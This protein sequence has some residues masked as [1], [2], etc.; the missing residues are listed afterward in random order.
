M[1]ADEP[2]PPAPAVTAAP[3][4]RAALVRLGRAHR[5]AAALGTALVI[6]VLLGIASRPAAPA[7][8]RVV[9]ASVPAVAAPDAQTSPAPSGD[10]A[11]LQ[12]PEPEAAPAPVPVRPVS[13]DTAAAP[14][15][16]D[17]EI[18]EPKEPASATAPDPTGTATE[19]PAPAPAPVKHVTVVALA[20]AQ[21]LDV[22]GP[23]TRAPYLA[24]ELR[25]RGLLLHRYFETAH[26]NLP[27][28]VAL[29][30]GQTTDAAARSLP[31]QLERAGLRWRA[32]VEGADA[33]A[34]APPAPCPPP[35]PAPDGSATPIDRNPFQFLA[36]IAAS[37]DCTAKVTGLAPLAA[38]LAAP[39]ADAPAFTL[40]VPGACDAG[41][42][43]ACPAGEPDGIARADAW[44]RE[45]IPPLL[46]APAF[47]DD[48]LV[49]VLFSEGRPE[50]DGRTGA[51][52]LSPHV[53]AGASSEET[54]NH[55]SLLRTIEDAFSLKPLA[56]AADSRVRALGSD[57]FDAPGQRAVTSAAITG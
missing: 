2:L 23:G 44:L 41:R 21:I 15:E 35:P 54:Y 17:E 8:Q 36:T 34:G 27:N 46:A 26:G 53:T 5:A 20:D 10:L 12:A 11:S 22:F 45:W 16:P 24:R 14:E 29:L 39:A 31:A 33:A 38:D 13:A 32:Y 51:L 56:L 9:L 48:G 4:L 52:L 25:A 30:S 42:V 47:A 6:G 49:V 7:A 3:A 28:L 40:V 57:V 43:G 19:T 1:R 37:P 55:Y 18:T 50:D